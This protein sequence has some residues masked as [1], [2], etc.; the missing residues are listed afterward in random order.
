MPRMNIILTDLLIGVSNVLIE[1]SN[2]IENHR[3]NNIIH[4]RKQ[5][6]K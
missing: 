2:N 3:L 4:R 5:Q 1:T 6:R